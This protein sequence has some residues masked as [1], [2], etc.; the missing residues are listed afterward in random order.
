MCSTEPL[1]RRILNV[2][3]EISR[4]CLSDWRGSTRTLPLQRRLLTAAFFPRVSP[5]I[6]D[7]WFDVPGLFPQLVS[8]SSEH[9][10]L[11]EVM[12]SHL[13]VVLAFADTLF[14]SVIFHD[15]GVS[16]MLDPHESLKLEIEQPHM[17]LRT[18]QFCVYGLLQ[19]H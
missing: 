14:R 6:S 10:R 15:S 9:V 12:L 18:S 19:S 3:F 16:R 2:V 8:R 13:L 7:Q 4:V 1:G 5:A 17:S 11:S